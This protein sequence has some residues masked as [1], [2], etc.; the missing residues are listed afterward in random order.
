[1]SAL[2]EKKIRYRAIKAGYKL[3]KSRRR[4][5]DALDYGRYR[6]ATHPEMWLVLGGE[7]GVTLEE[8]ADFLSE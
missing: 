2:D 7:F 4:D 6:L 8:V 1:M 5:P 3:V